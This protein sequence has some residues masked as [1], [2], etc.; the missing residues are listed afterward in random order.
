MLFKASVFCFCFCFCCPVNSI[1]I[2]RQQA[3]EAFI[4]C[5]VY[6]K[7]I[8][9]CSLKKVNEIHFPKY[10]K[11]LETVKIP[12]NFGGK[13][14]FAT[15]NIELADSRRLFAPCFRPALFQYISV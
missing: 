8:D 5:Y 3:V 4:V 12:M 14:M 10:S 7:C 15:R 1:F 2:I 6:R 11:L 9:L 13:N